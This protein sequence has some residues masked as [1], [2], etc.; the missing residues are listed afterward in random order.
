MPSNGLDGKWIVTL[1][2]GILVSIVASTITLGLP[3]VYY[4]GRMAESIEGLERGQTKLASSVANVVNNDVLDLKMRINT[5]EQ[6]Q[7]ILQDKLRVSPAEVLEQVKALQKQLN[8]GG[9]GTSR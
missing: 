6:R 1:L 3:A 7:G 9:Y 4:G 8:E 2:G 5:M